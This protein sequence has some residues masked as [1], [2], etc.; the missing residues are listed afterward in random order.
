MAA[1]SEGPCAIEAWQVTDGDCEMGDEKAAARSLLWI[2]ALGLIAIA[3]VN[4]VAARYL[5]AS[6]TNHLL[7][8]EGLLKQ[9]FLDSIL[10]TE[11][12][13]DTLF[14]T[15]APSP[16]L[17]SFAK[18]VKSLPGIVRANIYSPDG[19]IRHSTDA[20]LIGLHF[21]DNPELA[22]AFEGKIASSLET[23]SSEDKSEHLA[24]NLLAGEQVIEAYIPVL[25]TGGKVAAVVEFYR[26]DDWVNAMVSSIERGIT[27]IAGLSS[28]ILMLALLAALRLVRRPFSPRPA[29]AR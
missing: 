12:Q 9:E 21:G 20:N 22:E 29:P 24:L 11:A 8:R 13:P 2:M 15:P 1:A 23:I 28:A 18:H 27:M 5:T 6:M 16:T 10:A 19:F 7:E 25:S 26:K 14:A 3:A 4:I 17:A